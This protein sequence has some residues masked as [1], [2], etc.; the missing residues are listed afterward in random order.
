MA[1]RI[2][3]V[4]AAIVGF[5]ISHSNTLQGQTLTYIYTPKGSVVSDTYL[6]PEYTSTEIA[7]YNN[8]VA[9]TYPLATKI[10]DASHTYNCHAYAWHMTEGGNAVWIGAS[11]STAEDIYWT[12]GSYM[13]VC[14]PTFPAKVSYDSDDHS[15]VTTSTTGIFRSKWG[16]WP[17]MEHDKDYTPYNSSSLIYYVRTPSI[18]ISGPSAFCETATYSIDNLP[19]GLNVTWSATG[20]TIFSGPNTGSTVTI[21]NSSTEVITLTVTNDCGITLLTKNIQVGTPSFPYTPVGEL[22][23]NVFGDSYGYYAPDYAGA[24]YEYKWHV[25]RTTDGL[26]ASV[27]NGPP[28]VNAADV[29]FNFPGY[30]IVQVEIITDCMESIWSDPLLIEVDNSGAE[31]RS[32]S[33]F[34]NP[35]NKELTIQYVGEQGAEKTAVTEKA[36]A[37]KQFEVLLIDNKGNILRSAKNSN[38]ITFNTHDISDGIYYLHIKEKEKTVKKQIIIKH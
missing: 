18:S 24:V 15:A 30:Y 13:E 4:I 20:N 31:W 14:N 6:D 29:V 1:K 32:Y 23:P 27:W 10:A 8:Y 36:K 34:P 11:S 7:A 3:L 21:A 2:I 16:P 28:L 9:T 12:D 22:H 19:T 26:S 37:T 17:L 5:A 33:Y 25:N 38:P 35:A